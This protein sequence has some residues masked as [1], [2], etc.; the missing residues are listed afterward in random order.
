MKRNLDDIRAI[1]EFKAIYQ[2]VT[3]EMIET[4]R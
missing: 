1:A 4:E 2:Q 3:H